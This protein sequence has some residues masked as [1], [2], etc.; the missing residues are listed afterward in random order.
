[1]EIVCRTL[2]GL[3]LAVTHINARW[4]VYGTTAVLCAALTG[5]FPDC[6]FPQKDTNANKFVIDVS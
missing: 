5:L 1:M 2:F 6:L 3:F 4:L